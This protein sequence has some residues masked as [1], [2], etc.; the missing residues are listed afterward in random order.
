MSD[1]YL[2]GDP[3]VQV[4]L[5]RSARARRLSLRVSRLDGRVTL[6]MP[7]RLPEREAVAFLREKEDWVRKHLGNRPEDRHPEFGAR[8]P[9]LGREVEICPG[10]GRRA[11][12]RD[13]RLEVPGAEDRVPARIKAFLKLE[14]GLRLRAATDRY[15]AALGVSYG[16]LSLRDPR[17]RWGSC[18]SEGNLMYSWRLM[19]APEAVLDY[20]AAHEVAHRLEMNHSERFWAHVARICPD[21]AGH[22]R[23][24][25]AEGETLHAWR[26]E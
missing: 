12:L 3:P 14:A 24:L 7:K 26:F 6:S 9:V 22:R 4:T 17:S 5:R 2:D 11:V 10:T 20:V 23:W 25:H 1:I 21:H 15:A 8:I 19:M 18:T 13:G 16:R